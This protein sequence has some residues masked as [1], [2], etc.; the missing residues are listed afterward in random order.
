MESDGNPFLIHSL[1][2]KGSPKV[3]A[4]EK[5]SDVGISYSCASFCHYFIISALNVPGK[6]PKYEIAAADK[7]IFPTICLKLSFIYSA[8]SCHLTPSF[9]S[10]YV[11]FSA[12]T[13]RF[14]VM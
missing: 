2:V 7:K 12:A 1:I 8:N 3:F 14:S 9:A 5:F 10:N 4:T 6:G 11:N 13:N